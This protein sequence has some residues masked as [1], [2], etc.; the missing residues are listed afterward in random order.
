MRNMVTAL[1]VE[2]VSICAAFAFMTGVLA[3]VW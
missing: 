3:A 1:K 2:I